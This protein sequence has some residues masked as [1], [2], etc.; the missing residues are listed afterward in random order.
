MWIYNSYGSQWFKE[1]LTQCRYDKFPKTTILWEKINVKKSVQIV[2]AH[3]QD[4]CSQKDVPINHTLNHNMMNMIC[5]KK[6]PSHINKQQKLSRLLF[7]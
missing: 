5:R 2:Y 6:L 1:R 3:D 4:K 7:R